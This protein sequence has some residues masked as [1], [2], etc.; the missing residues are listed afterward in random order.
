MPR[1]MILA[2]V[3]ILTLLTFSQFS[4]AQSI[5]HG[6][7]YAL[8]GA[9]TAITDDYSSFYFNP[10]G[11]AHTG[12][13]GAGL[14]GNVA[15]KGVPLL[16]GIELGQG[17]MIRSPDWESIFADKERPVTGNFG[18]MAGLRYKTVG[19][20]I[21]HDGQI[22]FDPDD[23]QA[24]LRIEQKTSYN[25]AYS[26]QLLEPFLN[27]GALSLGINVKIFSAERIEYDPQFQE[28][29]ETAWGVG[30]DLGLM[31]QVTDNISLGIKAGD[32]FSNV[33]WEEEGTER[34]PP[35]YVLGGGLVLP[36]ID[37]SF[38]MDI[39]NLVHEPGT[40]LRAGIE[41]R[42]FRGLLDLRGGFYREGDDSGYTGGLGVNI[43][44]MNVDI[45]LGIEGLSFSKTS[46]LF[47]MG[48]DF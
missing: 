30:S 36:L 37:M 45:A 44:P 6:R 15:I 42:F 3:L 28:E 35:R 13:L 18:A 9:Y 8:G 16:P 5:Y 10:A 4:Q 23:D 29:L 14:G 25:L 33:F 24:R 1:G 46:L 43:G 48:A 26:Y 41:K 38:S 12:F 32:F 11:L 31:L 17:F 7:A 27:I 19:A 39:G 22:F 47:G 2:V 34:L 40:F 20:G 21:L